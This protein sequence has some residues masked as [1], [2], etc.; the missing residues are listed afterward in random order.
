M[1]QT[2]LQRTGILIT[3]LISSF[4][5]AM[6]TT[7]TGNMIP[8]IMVFYSVS[9]STAQWLTSGATLLSGIIIP[10]TA[11][12]I[13]RISN[14]LYYMIAMSFF[15]VGSF[16]ASLAPTFAVLMVSRLIQALGCGMLL[17]FAQ[18]IILAIYPKEKQGTMMAT[19]SM[20]ALVS[21]MVGPTYAGL[22]MDA[23]GI[24]GVFIDRK[25]VV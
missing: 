2:N 17:S 11:F 19:Y 10:I 20:A 12:L 1:R 6:S 16:T 13:K 8:N 9:S 22:L 14:K 4:I 23:V 25:S 3:L 7:V 5:T 21:A 15:T 18:I 24:K